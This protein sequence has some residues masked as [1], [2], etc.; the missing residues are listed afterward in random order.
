[1]MALLRNKLYCN[2]H[3]IFFLYYLPTLRWRGNGRWAD[4]TWLELLSRSG[5][6]NNGNNNNQNEI[7]DLVLWRIV[8]NALQCIDCLPVLQA[9]LLGRGSS[10][11][12][13]GREPGFH[14]IFWWLLLSSYHNL[15]L[16]T[17]SW[18]AIENQNQIMWRIGHHRLN[19]HTSH[20]YYHCNESE[21]LLHLKTKALHHDDA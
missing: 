13:C 15:I 14:S 1:M 2:E 3:L 9:G 11:P 20:P 12:A 4:T 16:M 19:F 8:Q 6:P 10:S 7:V 5:P 18:R 17:V 21:T